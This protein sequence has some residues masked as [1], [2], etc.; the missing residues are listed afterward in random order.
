[1]IVLMSAPSRRRSSIRAASLTEKDTQI[2]ALAL[3]KSVIA[4]G[5]TPDDVDPWVAKFKEIVSQK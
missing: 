4:I 1:M 5:G 3:L 2:M